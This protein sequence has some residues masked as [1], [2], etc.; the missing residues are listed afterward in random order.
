MF[1]NEDFYNMHRITKALLNIFTLLA[2]F[3]CA[4]DE[5]IGVECC[6]DVTKVQ[7][8][9]NSEENTTKTVINGLDIE[10]VQGDQ[11]S[12]LN[13]EINSIFVADESGSQ[14]V[15]FTG[16][17]YPS[18]KYYV[19]YPYN[20]NHTLSKN[21]I[22]YKIPTEQ[23]PSINS[24]DPSAALMAGV[25]DSD[26][27]VTM[28]N[29]CSFI[30]FELCS[31]D[32]ISVTITALGG[33]AMTG[34]Q[35]VSL[36]SELAISDAD[37]ES[38]IVVLKTSDGRCFEPGCYYACVS[39]G[40]LTGIRLDF[41]YADG[42][43][44]MKSK[45]GVTCPLVR[46]Y[47]TDFSVIDDGVV[48]TFAD[49]GTD[50]DYAAISAFGLNY[51][52]LLSQ[53]HP[54][55]FV[56]EYYFADL[57]EKLTEAPNQ[58]VFL[59]LISDNIVA[60]ADSYLTEA[61]P[62]Y[63]AEEKLDEARLGLKHIF[64]CAYAF[65]LT[66]DSKYLNK[67]KTDMMALCNFVDWNASQY[68]CVGETA[69]AV[70]IGY[71]WLY[72]KLTNKER[73]LIRNKLYKEAVATWKANWSQFNYSSNWNEVCWGGLVAASI[74]LYGKKVT[75]DGVEYGN[76]QLIELFETC[77]DPSVTGSN[78]YQLPLLYGPDGSFDEGYNYWNYGTGY[79]IALI[80]SLEN[81]FGKNSAAVT[82]LVNST[83]F[84]Q[85]GKFIQFMESPLGG[86][87]YATFSFAD[88]GASAPEVQ[89]PLYWFAE[90]ENNCSV[91]AGEFQKYTSGVYTNSN[92]ADRMFPLLPCII[93]DFNLDQQCN[94][95]VYPAQKLWHGGDKVQLIMG[96]NKWSGNKTDAYFAMKGGYP[97]RSH[98]HMDIGSFVF[99]YNGER[100]SHDIPLP[101]SYTNATAKM[102]QYDSSKSYGSLAQG[103]GR[104]W[105]FF[106]NNLG[107][108]TISVMN[109]T[110]DER[111]NV[112]DQLVG[113]SSDKATI[114]SI[115][116]TDSEIGGKMNLL[117]MYSD[118]LWG[119]KRTVKMVTDG[120]EFKKL[121]IIDEITSQL[122]TAPE[123]QWRMLTPASVQTHEDGYQ[124][125]TQNGK[126]MY[127]KAEYSGKMSEPQYQIW[128]ATTDVIDGWVNPVD[129]NYTT[130]KG[131]HVAG[132]TTT[133]NRLTS[134]TITT[135]ITDNLQ[136]L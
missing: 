93:K 55:L 24:F 43:T 22:S 20:E 74:A 109:G 119:I 112:S 36:E 52:G 25:A 2:F 101:W 78:A 44:G 121:V 13:N 134:V 53:N 7:L 34:G 83:G 66:G 132:F 91:L 39:P 62:V 110:Q 136:N 120:D 95:P 113:S 50:D 105:F 17:T 40:D 41:H 4:Y 72:G 68:L 14:G 79:E 47:I 98:G 82:G 107:H 27:C 61:T 97:K 122:M 28:M 65:N 116:E 76:Q 64:A 23:Y 26:R 89:W 1:A 86:R 102:Q 124:V 67:A 10:W 29:L 8:T 3:S 100:W 131:Y 84:M 45:E 71:D 94:S 104:W 69:M 9:L 37:S 115:I 35:T 56:D 135:T 129:R 11:L 12:V 77:V 21:V 5:E 46:N 31:D 80:R 57:R 130:T 88:G 118:K 38:D 70:A 51:D 33:E 126:T 6:G 59:K 90:H 30:K 85:T 87:T 106:T 58:N 96:R 111:S 73:E 48:R 32:V 133:I 75:V 15:V 127:L 60:N 99:D 18:D 114:E 49:D 81:S 117:P 125:L 123:I 63:G 92:C 103:S 108:S 16:F 54:R 42:S 19:C 128:E